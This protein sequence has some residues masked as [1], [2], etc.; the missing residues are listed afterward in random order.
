VG[1]PRATDRSRLE[2]LAEEQAA[3]RR[4]AT[5]VAQGA[6]TEALFALVAEQVAEVLDV[7]LVSIVRYEHDGTASERASVSPQGAMFEVGTRW[8][9]EGT[10]VVAQVL[11]SRGP[12]RIDD[13]TGLTGQIAETVRSVGIRSTVGIPIE[14][15]GRLWGA[16][17]VSSAEPEI[18]PADTEAH[19]AAFTELV[20]TAIANAEASE[21]VQRLAAEQAALRR[22]ATLVARDAPSTELFG[23]VAREA[24]ALLR[25]DFSAMLRFE[26]DG[27]VTPV[28][29]WAAVGDHPPV[30]ARWRT[31]PGDPTR[32]IAETGRAARVEDWTSVPGPIAA[33]MRRELGVS[34]SVGGP[35]MVDGRLWGGLAVHCKRHARL[36][37]DTESR[38]QKFTDLVATAIANTDARAE[39][40]R[41][42]HEQ[43]ALRRVATLVAHEASQSAVFTAIAEEIGRLLGT[44]EIQMLRFEEDRSALVMARWGRF[45]EILRVGSRVPI[46]DAAA[47]SQVFRTGRPARSD[48][49]SATGP[50][51]ER[52]RAAGIRSVLA[53]PILVEGRLWGAMVTGTSQDEPL[54]PDTELRL[55]QFTE[56]MAT[57][58]A[59]T[60]SRARADRLASPAT[61]S[62]SSLIAG[63]TRR[64]SR[65]A[66]G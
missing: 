23:A 21:E 65:P 18:L 49:R 6:P 60:E 54:P 63:R 24:G 20:A 59:N 58:I 9:I 28:A 46:E 40:T 48:Y 26:A 47:S 57:A 38:L 42:A 10:N 43:G 31:G 13:Y 45:E 5:L 17:V 15:A 37:P 1:G 50:L 51:A 7:P 19:L 53:T 2:Q 66:R 34:S 35:I 39:V 62:R 12:A 64:A 8:S 56:L 32:M 25:A 41:L 30:P 22:V 29:T 52:V 55:A 16:M 14:V 3:L 11:A 61:R 33:F 4:V 27:A 36:P 44:E